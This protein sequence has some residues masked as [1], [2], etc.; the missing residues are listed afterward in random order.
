[1]RK[2]NLHMRGKIA[3]AAAIVLLMVTLAAGARDA[4]ADTVSPPITLGPA[5]QSPRVVA[6]AP[7][8]GKVYV[9]NHLGNTLSVISTS[10]DSLIKTIPGVTHPGAIH[11]SDTGRVYIPNHDPTGGSLAVVDSGSDTQVA[12]SPVS[13]GGFSP[14]SVDTTPGD[15]RIVITNENS[16]SVMI[17]DHDLHVVKYLDDLAFKFNKPHEVLID[18][19]GT[20][21]YVAN[22]GSSEITVIN[23][24]DVTPTFSKVITV[25]SD[26]SSMRF[27]G[28]TLWVANFLSGT[29]SLINPS[30]DTVIGTTAVGNSPHGLVDNVGSTL[31][32][33][34]NQSS[35]TVTALD[36][37]GTVLKTIDVGVS[38]QRIHMTDDGKR[39]YVPNEGGDSVS[40]IDLSSLTVVQTLDGTAG[41][42]GSPSSLAVLGHSKVY[43]AN[44]NDNTVS[45]IK[46]EEAAPPAAESVCKGHRAAGNAV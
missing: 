40:V 9:S 11:I 16:N 13:T 5:P 18:P 24:A 36:G 4:V 14:S 30:D 26:P 31:V 35:N 29:I 43:V 12:G 1:M 28:N 32:L 15:S 3:A 39:A 42:G 45:V 6:I 19:S 41:I 25:G 21:A 23:I 10:S 46:I 33:V 17:L 37:S 20:K 27:V 44:K 2:S 22:K 8:V 38:P 7:S 34:A